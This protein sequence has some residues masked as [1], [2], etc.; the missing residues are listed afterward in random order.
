MYRKLYKLVRYHLYI[1]RSLKFSETGETNSPKSRII[2][3]SV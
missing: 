1:Q 3:D 2:K